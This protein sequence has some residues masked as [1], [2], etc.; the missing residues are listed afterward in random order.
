[1]ARS[2]YNKLQRMESFKH[3][4]NFLLVMGCIVLEV[5]LFGYHWLQHFQW[6]LAS[7]LFT[8]HGVFW[9]RGHVLEIAIYAVILI[10]FSNMYG[11][12]RLGYLKNAELIFSQIFATLIADLLIYAELSVMALRLFTAKH[13][14]I[15]FAEQFVVAFVYILII[16]KVYMNIFPPRKLLL[17]YGDRNPE[18]LVAKFETRKDKYK[19]T[20]RISVKEGE[21]AVKERIR[22]TYDSGLCNAVIIGDMTVRERKPLI[23]FCYS[24]DIRF[25]LLPKITDVILMGAEEL[26]VFDS[27]ILLTR[28]YSLTMEQR[29][30]KRTIDIVCS[31]LLLI[32]ASP[33]MLL[34]A[35]AVK[36]YDGGP[37]LYKQ[38]RCTRDMREFK[39]LKFRS[40]RVD[41]EKDGVAR[42][43][44][45]GDSRI[46]PVGNFIRKC[47]L[48][49]L[50][51]LI[52][53]L[54]GDMSFIGPRPLLI[55]YLPYY[56]ER[57][58][59]RHTVRPG[60]TGLAQ[61]SG[62]NL[63]NWD[64]RLELDAQ[65]V[66]NLSFAMDCKVLIMTVQ[67]VLGR[68]ETVAE[69]TNA[70]EGN[71]AQIRREKMQQKASEQENP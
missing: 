48:D 66:E 58:K 64:R 30:A 46:T 67:T 12:M 13:V 1:M 51:Q 49:E 24:E 25:Y 9:F 32:L 6:E 31:F 33:F 53:I 23:K 44:S 41:A 38:V 17:I 47:R 37:V 62:R 59:L 52:N 54:K 60:L 42:L 68:S 22:N 10:A 18:D 3:L 7:P 45:K 63:V 71:L 36:L 57:E 5:F 14:L 16:N 11:G 28:E 19:I 69:D 8:P 15:M 65:Y 55:E 20:D 2:N 29:F 35:L 34:T 39:I 70:A 50:P 26:H 56:T 43:A 4:I 40:M 21:E 27:P 61:A